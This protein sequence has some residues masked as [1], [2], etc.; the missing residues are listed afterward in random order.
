MIKESLTDDILEV[1]SKQENGWYVF[2]V[3]IH[4]NGS[5]IEVDQPSLTRCLDITED[6]EEG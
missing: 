2:S 4:K 3:H 1:L 6:N 5:R